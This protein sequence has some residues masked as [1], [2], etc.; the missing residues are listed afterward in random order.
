MQDVKPF[1]ASRTI[2]VN[3]I[4]G[5]AGLAGA[6]GIDFG[7]TAEQQAQIVGGILIVANIILRLV[8]K[9]AVK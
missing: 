2:W 3:I 1:W 9:T 7:L 6:F 8:T 4:A 5:V